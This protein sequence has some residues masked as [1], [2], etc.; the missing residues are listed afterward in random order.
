MGEGVLLKQFGV[1]ILEFGDDVF[2]EEQGGD[3]E[4]RLGEVFVELGLFDE[5][6]DHPM[7]IDKYESSAIGMNLF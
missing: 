6:P 4:I 3:G 7:M 1:L 2:V 5:V